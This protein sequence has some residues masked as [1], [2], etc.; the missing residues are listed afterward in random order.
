MGGWADGRYVWSRLRGDDVGLRTA[1]RPIRP[2]ADRDH[3]VS[4]EKPLLFQVLSYESPTIS[5][6]SSSTT[7]RIRSGTSRV[8]ISGRL[9]EAL[10]E[11]APSPVRLHPNLA[12][13][14][15]KKVADLRQSLA[16][17]SIRSDARFERAAG[18]RLPGTLTRPN[19]NVPDQNGPPPAFSSSDSGGV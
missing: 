15:R 10:A 5:K 1:H 19:V 6:S 2:S 7:S 17:P 4:P 11:P 12:D 13:L 16:D 8:E 18:N 3:G 9:K 14:Y